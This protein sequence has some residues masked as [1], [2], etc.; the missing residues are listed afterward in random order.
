MTA[1]YDESHLPV[2]EIRFR[3]FGSTVMTMVLYSTYESCIEATM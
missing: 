1:V 2:K 3:V